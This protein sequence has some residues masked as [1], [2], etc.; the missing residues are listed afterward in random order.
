MSS[1]FGQKQSRVLSTFIFATPW[2]KRGQNEIRIKR[3][4]RKPKRKRR[5]DFGYKYTLEASEKLCGLEVLIN[6]LTAP[7][8]IR[9]EGICVP[10]SILHCLLPF[11]PLRSICCFLF[12]PS[13]LQLNNTPVPFTRWPQP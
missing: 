2:S 8:Q 7:G 1:S 10:F 9:A 13:W 6:F 4:N 11:L 12:A 5:L 3:D